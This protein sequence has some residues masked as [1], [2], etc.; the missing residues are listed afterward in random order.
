[1]K[2]RVKRIVPLFL[3]LMMLIGLVPAPSAKAAGGAENAAISSTKSENDFVLAESGTVARIWFDAAEERPVQ[4]VAEDLQSDVL[5][6]G[7]NYFWPAMHMV[8]FNNTEANISVLQEYGVVFGTSHC[9][10][11][12]RTNK[13]EWNAWCAE[14]GYNLTLADWDYTAHKD[15]MIEYWTEGVTRHK[16]SDVQW[17]VRIHYMH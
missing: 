7:G 13:H 15:K 4:R 16:D 9:D 2:K 6:L 10:M 8:G 11:L 12:G 1:M 5:R 17:T 14:K 3:A